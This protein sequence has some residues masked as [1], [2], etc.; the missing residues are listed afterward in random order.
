MN[1]TISAGPSYDV[2]VNEI[3]KVGLGRNRGFGIDTYEAPKN[4]KLLIPSK[5]YTVQKGKIKNFADQWAQS[6]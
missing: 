5:S 1:K 3:I 4:E 2:S 6:K